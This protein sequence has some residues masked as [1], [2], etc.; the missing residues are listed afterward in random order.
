MHF[1]CVFELTLAD[2]LFLLFSGKYGQTV[3]HHE[4]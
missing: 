3:K 1:I 2:Q 4:Q